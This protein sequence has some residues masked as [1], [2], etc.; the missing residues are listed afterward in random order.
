MGLREVEAGECSVVDGSHLIRDNNKLIPL[1]KIERNLR[2]SQIVGE[3][4]S[5]YITGDF[6]RRAQFRGIN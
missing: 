6:S 5:G 3:F 4:L 1:A 2:V